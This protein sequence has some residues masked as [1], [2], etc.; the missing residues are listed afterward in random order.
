M[1]TR[2]VVVPFISRLGIENG[3][4]TLTLKVFISV[5]LGSVKISDHGRLSIDIVR[6]RSI[7]TL[8][9][10]TKLKEIAERSSLR[11]GNIVIL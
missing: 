7:A 4:L 10:E 3:S 5:E 9:G 1:L 11:R 2:A 8:E 6:E